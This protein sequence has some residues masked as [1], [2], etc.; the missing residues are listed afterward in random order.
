MTA[1]RFNS[2]KKIF[3]IYVGYI[4]SGDAL[5]ILWGR[6]SA[7]GSDPVSLAYSGSGTGRVQTVSGIFMNLKKKNGRS[8][9]KAVN[10]V[11]FLLHFQQ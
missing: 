7:N 2:H 10:P 4:M 8:A 11:M 5:V 9:N 1:E 6:A 3:Y